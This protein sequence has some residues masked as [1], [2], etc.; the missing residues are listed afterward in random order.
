MRKDG[1]YAGKRH[2]ILSDV[3]HGRVHIPDWMSESVQEQWGAPNTE[4]RFSKIRNTINVALGNQ[5][6]RRNPSVQA[7]EKWEADLEF[8]DGELRTQMTVELNG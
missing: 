5:K 3:L 2:N 1:P 8:M 7:I 6:G 4:E